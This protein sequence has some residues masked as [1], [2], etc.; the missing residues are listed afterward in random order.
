MEE[1]FNDPKVIEKYKKFNEEVLKPNNIEVEIRIPTSE[2]V[3][4]ILLPLWKEEV[5]EPKYDHIFE[6]LF[7]KK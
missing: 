3:K 6:N 2:E 1:R 5:L 7:F 4:N